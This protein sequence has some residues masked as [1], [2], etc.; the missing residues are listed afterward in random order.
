[1]KIKEPPCYDTSH[2][3]I[4]PNFAD[5]NPKP[6]L[7]F[8]KATEGSTFRDAK[9]L[10]YWADLKQD[11]IF[12]G[13]YHF[14]RK[15]VAA[16]PQA[17]NFIATVKA[18][19]VGS[20]DIFAL[21][22]EEG[23]ESATQLIAWLDIVQA[24]FPNNLIL[25]YSRKNILDPIA[26]T[27]QQITRLKKHNIWTAGYPENP[28]I[29]NVPPSFYIPNQLHWGPVWAWQY[30]EHATITGITGDVDANWLAPEIIAYLGVTPPADTITQP[31]PGLTRISGTRYGWPFEL[32]ISDPAQVRYEVVCCN[33]LETP[34]QVA[35]RKGAT[36]ATNGGEPEK[37]NGVIVGSS[38]YTVSNG[39]VCEPRHEAVPSLQIDGWDTL[40]FIYHQNLA[41]VEHALSGLRYLIRDG[42]IQ[43]Y[44]DGTEPQYT[45]GHA[46]SIHGTDA[47]GR[48]MV[49]Q[50]E[51]IHPSLTVFDGMTLKE[52]ATIMKQYGALTA[53]DSGGGGDVACILDGQSLIVPENVLNGVH[54]ERPLP[55]VFLIYTNGG[56]MNGTAK[57][58]LGNTSTVRDEPTRYGTGLYTLPPGNTL[59]FV[60]VVPV[61]VSG[62][63]DNP[64]DQWFE[65]PDGN[66]VNYILAAKK[67]YNI[68]TQPST[69]PPPATNP[70]A[71]VT[72]TDT[73]GK[74]FEAVDVE[75]KPKG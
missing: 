63:S 43:S 66:F 61:V 53:F 16:N 59:Q 9:F 11:G 10:Q 27:P 41:G 14:H 4:V 1:M 44:L 52:A 38:D 47:Q 70:K 62:G 60:K 34:S 33:P 74:V 6:L 8:T 57:E 75:L 22:V 15:D 40:V 65:M 54:F 21:D 28:D 20:K 7:V 45:E 24:E 3:E 39:N 36:L 68:L 13:A 42:V 18:G 37:V 56:S 51:G 19:G 49:M 12:R 5:V 58:A 72:F 67:Y 32:F 26:M 2:W 29:Y 73:A 71:T 48:A 25:I 55:S 17:Q 23:G 30:S 31:H 69:E 50:S 64:A 35:K 46:R